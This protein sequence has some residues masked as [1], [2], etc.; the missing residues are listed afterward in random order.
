MMVMMMEIVMMVMVMVMMMVIT[1]MMMMMIE[2]DLLPSIALIFF[3]A[4]EVTNDSDCIK[5]D[6]CYCSV[7]I[8][9]TIITSIITTTT[10]HHHHLLNTSS[11]YSIVDSM[12]TITIIISSL[13]KRIRSNRRGGKADVEEGFLFMQLQSI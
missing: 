6:G 9:T 13:C 3:G 4:E 11:H 7:A 1:V 10:I 5:I 2:S 12:I 8:T